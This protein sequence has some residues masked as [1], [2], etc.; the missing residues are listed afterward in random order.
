MFSV[1]FFINVIP[2]YY[3]ATIFQPQFS[4]GVFLYRRL[5]STDVKL[6]LRVSLPTF[7][8]YRRKN[9]SNTLTH[10]I[11]YINQNNSD[12]SHEPFIFSNF[13]SIL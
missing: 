7:V 6:H 2:E 3:S 11:A 12:Q 13:P 4:I 10:T 5:C 9:D 1:S 8:L